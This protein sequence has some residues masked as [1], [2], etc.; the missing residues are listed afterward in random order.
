M[1]PYPPPPPLSSNHLQPGGTDIF[2][3][4]QLHGA[5]AGLDKGLV[6]ELAVATM[7]ELVRMAQLGEPLWT[8][9]LVI[10]SATIE[11][12]NEEEYARGFPRGVGPKYPGL[13]SE[14]SRE[15]VVIIMNHVNLI[16]ILMDVNQWSTLFSSIVSRAATLEVLSTGIAGNYNGALQLMTAEFQ[17]PSPLVPTCESQ[18]LCYCKQYTHGSWRV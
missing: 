9:A 17:M 4:L 7:E 11:T 13:Q 3:D 16:E 14:A 6:V 18:F 2:G 8:P 1:A 10:D 15:T 12:L 5:A